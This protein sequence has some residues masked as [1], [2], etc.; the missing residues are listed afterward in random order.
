MPDE[1]YDFKALIVDD[2]LYDTRIKIV[3]DDSY[4]SKIKVVSFG[5]VYNIIAKISYG[6]FYDLR[7]K[8]VNPQDRPDIFDIDT[9]LYMYPHDPP[10]A[11]M[12]FIV[13]TRG[14]RY[15]VPKI[16]NGW[17]SRQLFS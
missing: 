1:D 10:F 5:D 6:E 7:V 13:E 11:R 12:S 4:E 8:V 17:A 15:K 16:F 14:K 3:T 2:Y 9:R